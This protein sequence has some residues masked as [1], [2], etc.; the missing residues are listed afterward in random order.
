MELSWDCVLKITQIFPN[1]EE[2]RAPHNKIERLTSIEGHFLNLKLLDIEGNKIE[3]WSEVCKLGSAPRLEQLNLE[4]IGLSSIEFKGDELKVSAF[5][6]LKKLCIVNNLLNE[7]QSIG[8][9]NRLENLD[10]LKIS[11]NPI[12]E[13]EDKNTV[14]Q[15]IV[16]KIANLKILNGVEIEPGERRGAEYD[17]IKK[18]GLEWLQAKGTNQE[19][20]F[21]K[22]HNR[23]L[24]LIQK[25]G[26]PE[27]SELT[28]KPKVIKSSLIELDLIYEGV[29]VVKKLPPTMTVQKLMIITQKLFCLNERPHLTYISSEDSHIEIPLENELKEIGVYAMKNGDQIIVRK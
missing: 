20:E 26:E 18:Y 5:S 12:I 27:E 13:T 6:A 8:E 22:S 2:F 21:L 15:I 10:S 11:K 14:H 25:Y 4:N 16:A 23:Y 24:E 7:W 9:L 1:L 28:T 19:A 29:N 3:K 17:Y